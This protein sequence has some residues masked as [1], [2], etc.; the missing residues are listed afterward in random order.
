MNSVKKHPEGRCES[1]AYSS[2]ATLP[3]D[4]LR[5]VNPQVRDAYKSTTGVLNLFKP[6]SQVSTLTGYPDID[7]PALGFAGS[8]ILTYWPQ[9][10]GW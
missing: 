7:S 3:G 2:P 5:C 6:I 8:P 1:I 9:E 10:L 4:T